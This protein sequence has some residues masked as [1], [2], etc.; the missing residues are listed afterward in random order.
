M[1]GGVVFYGD[2]DG[3]SESDRGLFCY[4]LL[5]SWKAESVDGWPVGGDSVV[6]VSVCSKANEN[7]VQ[8]AE[9]VS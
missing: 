4:D 5:D 9:V 7:V 3:G 1:L 2:R 6:G 8:V